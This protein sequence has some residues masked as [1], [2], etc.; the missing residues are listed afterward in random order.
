V[1]RGVA[2]SPKAPA[3]PSSVRN[4]PVQQRSRKTLELVL[5]AAGAAFD[6]IGVDLCS[7]EEIAR[8]AGV[9]IGTLYRFFPSKTALIAAL[10]ERYHEQYD[11]VATPLFDPSRLATPADEIVAEFFSGFTRLVRTQPGWQGLTRAGELFGGRVTEQWTARLEQ[12]VAIQVPGLGPRRRRSAAVMIQALTGWLLLY[13][14]EVDGGL[15][16]SL[17]EAHAVLTGYLMELRREAG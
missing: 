12:L 9:S 14:V 2:K 13:A 1:P 17:R 5:A 3:A 7:M 16:A 6:D 4:P 15:E 11:A 8:R 10:V